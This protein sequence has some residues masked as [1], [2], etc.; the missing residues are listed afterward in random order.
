M[1]GATVIIIHYKTLLW[2]LSIIIALYIIT[3]G[4]I[5]V[6]TFPQKNQPE[7]SLAIYGVYKTSVTKI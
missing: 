5:Q 4:F 1:L 2:N 7:T 6:C 3:A